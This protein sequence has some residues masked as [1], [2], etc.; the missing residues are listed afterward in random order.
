[1]KK[2]L[3]FVAI[4]LA[5]TAHARAQ[6]GRQSAPP[7]LGIEE[8]PVVNDEMRISRGG[9]RYYIRS[10]SHITLPL[11]PEGL[12]QLSLP[13]PFSTAGMDGRSESRPLPLQFEILGPYGFKYSPPGGNVITLFT[14]HK[15]GF[16]NRATL[17]IEPQSLQVV[18]RNVDYV[19]V[20]EKDGYPI[21]L[22]PGR[23]TYELKCTFVSMVDPEG[24]VIHAP[25]DSEGL[26]RGKWVGRE[27][28]SHGS[29]SY[30]EF[31]PYFDPV[32][33]TVNFFISQFGH[34]FSLFHRPNISVPAGT[35]LNFQING[36]KATYTAEA[37]PAEPI[38]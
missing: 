18:I 10:G 25:R 13:F 16:K 14:G 31:L 3:L 21:Y 9:Q 12:L 1:M 15:S 38:D 23:W 33:P 37:P 24:H 4:I 8:S 35:Q 5:L 20:G 7:T 17:V 36:L 27:R 6:S 29:S 19:K 34:V 26:V 28:G 11:T 32:G 22:K 30:G 2:I